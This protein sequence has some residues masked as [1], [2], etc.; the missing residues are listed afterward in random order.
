MLVDELLIKYISVEEGGCCFLTGDN[1]ENFIEE[2]N[3]RGISF[4]ERL[5]TEKGG[6]VAIKVVVV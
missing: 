2:M 1:F 6:N 3:S 4:E 5:L